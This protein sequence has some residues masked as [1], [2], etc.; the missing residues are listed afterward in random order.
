MKRIDPSAVIGPEV[1]L[2]DDVEIGAGC[3]LEGRIT[4]GPGTS[5]MGYN[6]LR[7]PLSIGA[8]NRFYPFACIGFEP[9]D[10]KFD[11]SRAGAGTVIGNDN[12]LR[13]HVTIHRATSET[14][15]TRIGNN[16]MLMVGSHAGHDACV[17]NRCIFANNA[18]VGGHAV[19]Y[20]GVNLGG[21]GGV[22]QKVAVGRLAFVSGTV[23]ITRNVPPFMISRSLRTVG[24]I[25]IVG[26]RRS[27]MSRDEIDQVKWIF[28]TLFLSRNTRPTMVETL[29]ERA[30]ESP[31]VAETLAFLQTHAGPIAELEA[32]KT[33]REM[34]EADG[35]AALSD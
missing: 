21:C 11:P 13:E 29:R 18:L 23:G 31:V 9:Q 26:L 2:A 16:N 7:G 27:G 25:N 20:D 12:I 34:T 10:Y 5:L 33:S 30:T 28:R 17:G 4:I 22:A 8:N 14:V 35:V 3:R 19:I 24:G 6:F 1:E 15:P 32:G